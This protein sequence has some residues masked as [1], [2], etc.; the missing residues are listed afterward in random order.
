MLESALRCGVNLDFGCSNGSCGQCKVKILRGQVK[1]SRHSDYVLSE[2]ELQDQLVLACCVSAESDLLVAARE[3]GHVDQ[4]QI[5]SINAKVA[6]IEISDDIAIIHL[7]TARSTP[8]RFLAGQYLNVAFSNELDQCFAIASCPCDGSHLRIHAA[9]YPQTPAV[10]HIFSSLKKNTAVKLRGPVGKFTL[11][12]VSCR[13]LVFIAAGVGFAPIASLI[14]HAISLEWSQAIYL[15]RLCGKAETPYLSNYCRSWQDAL[16]N[17][18]YQKIDALPSGRILQKAELPDT[19]ADYYVALP[20]AIQSRL[21]QELLEAGIQQ[22]RIKVDDEGV[23]RS[24]CH[25]G[26]QPE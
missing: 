18:T 24:Q 8:L 1:Q 4:V 3:A 21:R 11:H 23:Y 12:E 13:P 9:R 19:E 7:R 26:K 17:F 16:D 2:Q 20:S 10:A 5:Q 14:E 15:L 25:A 22:E 6:C